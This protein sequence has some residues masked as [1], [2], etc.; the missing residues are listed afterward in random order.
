[1]I[2]SNRPARRRSRVLVAAIVFASAAF[3][4][5]TSSLRGVITDA[6]GAVI[7]QTVVK[8]TNVD[9]SASRSTLSNET[10]DYLFPQVA[11]GSYEVRA[12][13]K[14]FAV[15]VQRVMLQVN[16]PATMNIKLE[17]GQVTE[18]VNVSAEA[19]TINTVDASVGN[20][21]TEMQVRQL[22]LQTRNV[23]ELLSIQPGVTQTGEVLG[24]RRD[25]NNVTLDGVEVNDNQNAGVSGA[26]PGNGNNANSASL[27]DP[28]F[29]AVLPVPLDSVQEFRVTISGQG[30]SF[31]RSAGGQVTLITK[32]GTNQLHGS[33]YEYHRNTVTAAN[34]WFSNRAGIKREALV[35]NQFGASVG[36]RI[37]KDR[38]FFFGNFEQ[39]I[40]AS[41]RAQSRT[42][43]TETLKQG[44]VRF[45]MN[46]GSTRQLTTAEIATVD[47]IKLGYS[48]AMRDIL[49]KYPT[50]NDPSAGAD[51]GL[52]FIG[53]VFNAPFRQDD[54]AY[55]AKMDF[56]LDKASRHTLSLRGTLAD[57]ALDQAVAQFPGQA[58][59]SKLLNNS[60]GL[61]AR[62]TSVVTPTII[63]VSSFGLTRVG[64][65]QSGSQ[66][67]SLSFD[68]ISALE[69][70]TRGFTRVAPSYSVT[71]DTTWMKGRH[72]VNFGADLRF[73][74]N[75][76]NSFANAFASYSFSRN[77]LRGL[78]SDISD[79]VLG[80]VRGRDGI[81]ASLSD[82]QSVQRAMGVLYGLVNQYSATY[83]YGKDGTAQAVGTPVSRAFSTNEYEFYLQDSW[84]TTQNLTLTMGLRYS[85]F[86]VPYE[87]NGVQVA[88]TTGIDQFFAERVAASLSGTPGGFMPNAALT[89]ALAGPANNKAGWYARDK[90]NFSPRLSFAYAPKGG[91]LSWLTGNG[92]VIRGGAAMLYDRFGSDLVV[93][94]DRT[95]S[96]GLATQ[97]TQ[98]RNT[99][100]TTSSRY[101]SGGLPALP[102]APVGGK[103]PLTPATIL[104][105]F[106]S[107]VGISPDLVAPY[108]YLLNFNIQR[109]LPGKMTVEFGYVGRLQHKSLLQSDYFQPLTRFKDPKSGQT[110]TEASAILRKLSDNG[111]TPA[112]VKANPNL[113][114][115]VP[116]FENMAPLLSNL[117]FNGSASANYFD[118]AYNQYAGSELDALNDI[119][120]ERYDYAPNCI[121]ITGCNTFFALQNAGMRAWVNAGNGSFHGGT[122]SVRRPLSNGF[123]F[124]FNYTL[125][126]SIDTSSAAE[127]G[128]GNG[129]AVIQDAFNPNAFRGS[130]DFDI[131][132][133]I[134]A[135]GL[136]ELPFGKGKAFAGNANS[137]VDQIIGGWQ[138][139]TLMRYRSGLPTTISNAGIYPTNYLNSALA[140]LAPGSSAPESS[141]GYNQN[142]VPSIYR[143]TSAINSYVGQY[144]GETGQR[145]ILRL[146]GL[147][148]FDIAVAKTFSLPFEGHRL[149]LRGEAFNAFNN[150]N[151][152]NPSLRLDR[153]AT[154]GDFQTALPARVMQFALRYEF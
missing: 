115:K 9:T 135:N 99:D 95:G 122:L 50:G 46:D 48:P 98:P 131:R 130:S 34:N 54:K 145:A 141:L 57:N 20:P 137:V 4:Q 65:E 79:A 85:S 76:R 41:A 116:F 154:F 101:G 108:S 39:R 45:R 111:L 22:P 120:R 12:E 14:G 118:L 7:P 75:E 71:N 109:E 150:V 70:F 30:A 81:S 1:M 96:P 132:H 11:P 78:G 21:F 151:F 83:N 47:P 107:Q 113:V 36:G 90:N 6:N 100:F 3:A 127:S 125:S 133:N 42:V 124:D 143:N 64:L 117:Y 18:T 112:Q 84:K 59:A 24:A 139:S 140:I 5:G 119:D 148:N 87:S 60:R 91:P 26:G 93:E 73:I 89:Y 32:G 63:N 146:A 153:S 134:T 104:G 55:V 86:G 102:A 56:N 43:P 144:P 2:H 27:P 68:G 23:V 67:N 31:G 58:P 82:A 40:D 66:S 17:I 147:L 138:I 25:Q 52:N 72:T 49:S 106:N 97:V 35:R 38:V 80:Y 16:T 29:N 69:N 121:V 53:F 129:G 13:Q 19:A 92:G 128:A 152:F 8:L 149:Q 126:H 110:W 94:F 123:S 61:G 88:T 103:F 10:G 74:R 33:A 142:G 37:I 62:Y 51:R 136:Y 114:P 44:I 28:G 15:T 77:T 105:G